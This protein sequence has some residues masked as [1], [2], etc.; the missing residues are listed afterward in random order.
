MRPQWAGH[1]RRIP[2]KKIAKAVWETAPQGKRPIGRS[3]LR[4]RDNV[5]KDLRAMNLQ[6]GLRIMWAGKCENV[7]RS[8]QKPTQGCKVRYSPYDDDGRHCGF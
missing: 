6:D 7:W 2:D 4:W 3:R 1:V 8:R 5:A